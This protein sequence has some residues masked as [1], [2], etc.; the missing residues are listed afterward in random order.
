MEHSPDFLRAILDSVSETIVVIDEAGT[1]Q[2]VNRAWRD[3]GENNDACIPGD[4][5]QT[6]NYLAA[7]DKASAMG[8]EFG[9]G[10]AEGIRSVVSGRRPEFYL[11][12][13]CHSPDEKRWFMMRVAPLQLNE[14]SYFVIVHQNITERKLAEEKVSALARIDGLTGIANRRAFDEFL[15]EEVRRCMRLGKPVSMAIVDLDHFK[16]LNDTFGHQVGDD[17]LRRVASLLQETVNRPSDTCARYGGEEFALIWGDTS[18]EQARQLANQFLRNL[19]EAKILNLHSPTGKY[20]TASIGLTS[21][22]PTS[23]S[24]MEK[25]IRQADNML[26]E[27]KANG[28]NRIEP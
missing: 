4:H 12:Y 15:H 3:Y 8:D 16:L 18:L 25:L 28:R 17:T 24:D 27:A 7:C 13:P 1:I 19:T 9:A 22:I 2:Y 11:E 21:I 5:W 10:A 14:G 26:Y 23:D 6:L 20:L